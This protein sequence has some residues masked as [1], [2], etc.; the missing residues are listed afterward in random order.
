MPITDSCGR[1]GLPGRPIEGSMGESLHVDER[2]AYEASLVRR[3]NALARLVKT[4]AGMRNPVVLAMF[5]GNVLRI[6]VPLCGEQLRLDLFQW[7]GRK[8]REDHR[9]CPFC[10][11]RKDAAAPLCPA[12]VADMDR[13]DRELM[14][15]ETSQRTP[16]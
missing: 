13:V 8:F 3:V 12:C 6:A 15:S 11:A 4:R 14:L 10:G 7:L 9:L 16:S 1:F 2:A 5:V